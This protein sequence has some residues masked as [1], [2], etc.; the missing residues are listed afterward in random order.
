MLLPSPFFRERLRKPGVIEELFE[1]LLSYLRSQS[2]EAR[3]GQTI[4][5]TL[6]PVPRQRDSR[7]DNK[8]IKENRM[9]KGW[10]ENPDRLQQ[11]D[12]NARKVKKDGIN[13]Y[14]YKN[15]ICID[16]EHG[17]IR[18]Y[19]VTPA[20]IHES[21]ML[22]MLLDPETTHDYVWADSA[23]AGECFEHLLKH[24]GYEN[25]IHKK[26]SRNHPLSDTGIERNR[27]K[28]A[29]RACVEHVLAA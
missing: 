7:E 27:I 18:R 25:C 19:A 15:N 9:P 21:Q 20:N 10:D 22:P 16:M 8:E 28:S 3:G 4:D 1:K 29:V 11:K 24:G 23:H 14:G 12:L 26:G 13:H 2:L 5:A 6:V 17:F